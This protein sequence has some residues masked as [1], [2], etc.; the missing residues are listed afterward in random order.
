MKKPS[1]KEAPYGIYYVIIGGTPTIDW[2]N[3]SR[4]KKGALNHYSK[5]TLAIAEAKKVKVANNKVTS[6]S[7]IVALDKEAN[8]YKLETVFK[9]LRDGKPFFEITDPEHIA[10]ITRILLTNENI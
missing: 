1:L 2:Y 5:F 10:T 4:V 7:A 6:A 3:T 9:V 8:R